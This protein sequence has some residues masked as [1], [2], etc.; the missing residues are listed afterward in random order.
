MYAAGGVLPT[1][2]TVTLTLERCLGCSACNNP[3]SREPRADPGP[4]Q[5]LM[6]VKL[7]AMT[8]L[9]K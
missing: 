2:N 4:A 5:P 8:S 7:K 6:F 1:A 3:T 9:Y